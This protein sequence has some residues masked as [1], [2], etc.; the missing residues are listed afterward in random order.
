VAFGAGSES[1]SEASERLSYLPYSTREPITLAVLLGLTVV[2]FAFVAGLS[3]LHEA[4][5]DALAERWSS[6]GEADLSARRFDAAV[7]DFRTALLYSRDNDSYQLNMAE[8]LIGNGRT[9]EANTYLMNLWERQP[10]NGLVNLELAR[11]AAGKGETE[12]ALR[13]YHNAIYATWPG[14]RELERQ[15]ARLELIELLLRNH[16]KA[17]AQSELIALAANLG[18][19][20]AER[21]HVGDLFL[22]CQDDAHALAEYQLSLKTKPRDPAA[23]AGAGRAAFGLGR[24]TLAQRYLEEAVAVAPGDKDSAARLEI[25]NL[26][27]EMDPFRQQIRAAQRD[28][29]VVKAYAAAGARLNSCSA[30]GSST[31]ATEQ[32]DLAQK[33]TTLK[34]R[35]TEAGLR[36][37]PDLV[38]NAMEMVFDIERQTD[39][40]CAASTE[41]DT[42]LLLIAKMHEGL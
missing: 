6:R 24:Y 38:N 15:N 31:A 20:P 2:F 34:P 17:Q 33:W 42:A 32:Q 21:T 1:V 10:E 14:N 23:L 36:R 19:D 35:V 3:R 13:Y 25:A 11:I 27:V 9:D 41:T 37:D 7:L 4:Q 28:R 29:V 12:K 22:E 30:A 39:G 16:A 18:D 8:A 26:V 40:T 5:Q